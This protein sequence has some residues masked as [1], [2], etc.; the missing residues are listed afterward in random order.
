MCIVLVSSIIIVKP[1]LISSIK[2]RL[3]YKVISY[4]DFIHVGMAPVNKAE[5]ISIGNGVVAWLEYPPGKGPFPGAI[6]F[7]G[8]NSSGSMQPASTILRRALLHAGFVVLS[9]DHPGYGHSA[10]PDSGANI[11]AWDPLPIVL[12]AYSKLRSLPYVDGIIACGHS[13]GTTDV[14]RLLNA[15]V[16]LRGAVL[17]GASYTDPSVREEYWYNRFHNDRGITIRLTRKKVLEIRRKFYYGWPLIKTLSNNHPMI[18]FVRFGIE[19]ADIIA[20]R[21]DLYRAISGR[22]N[23]WDL[24]G[25]THYFSSYRVPGDLIIGDTRIA[26]LLA[27]KLQIFTSKL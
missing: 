13:M 8:A 3:F 17:F 9:V 2:P 10:N 22:K 21:D 24:V 20:M 5:R 1:N 11:N 12:N 18:L 19:H 14:L 7:H 15:K 6:N 16:E 27:S 25:S 4:S 23:K 26:R